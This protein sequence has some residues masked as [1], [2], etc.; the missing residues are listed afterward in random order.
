MT[1]EQLQKMSNPIYATGHICGNDAAS[2]AAELI[3]NRERIEIDKQVTA[4]ANKAWGGSQ[5]LIARLT[6]DN[7]A[8]T[9]WKEKAREA[10]AKAMYCYQCVGN[11]GF[12]HCD[13]Y[14]K[15]RDLIGGRDAPEPPEVQS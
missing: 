7:A 6:A 9:A 8:L 1:N 12:R 3:A 2:M 5:Q 11:C 14:K 15:L 13:N 10:I 4:E